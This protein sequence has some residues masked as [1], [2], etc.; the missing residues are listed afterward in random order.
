[1]TYI[2][3]PGRHHLLTNFQFDYLNQIA[4][5]GLAGIKDIDGKSFSPNEKVD[6]VVFAITS[7]NHANTRRN[8]LPLYQRAM[9]VQ[10]FSHDL[11]IKTTIYDINDIGVSESFADYVLKRIYSRSEGSLKLTP[12]NTIVA[13]STPVLEMYKKLGFRILPVELLSKDFKRYADNLPWEIIEEVANIQ[14]NWMENKLYKGKTHPAS[15]RLWET[16]DIGDKVQQ[17]FRDTIIG[18][19]GD[20][21]ETRD[22]NTYVR[23]MDHSTEQKYSE[24]S[25]FVK[26]G[27][28]GDIGCAVGSWIKFA[29][30]DSRLAESDFYGIEVTRKLYDICE[31]RKD[32]GEFSS[33]Y[34]FFSRK[35]AITGLVFEPDSMD[36]IL[37]SSLTHEIESYGGRG[38]LL[39]FIKNRAAELNEGGRWIN[40]DVV[41]PDDGSKTVY[42]ELNSSDGRNDDY[43]QAIGN[44]DKLKEYLDGLSTYAKFLRFSKDFRKN[45]SEQVKYEAV[46][47]DNKNLIKLQLKDACEFV[48]KK[49]YTDN[50][51]SEMHE[52][53][54]FW[55][56][57]DWKQHLEKAGLKVHPQSKAFVNPWVIK[58]RVQGK[59]KLYTLQD[60][61]LNEIDYPVSNMVLVAEKR[62]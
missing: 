56:F 14:D 49:D 60:K 18:E 28:I 57:D 58:K 40:R 52:T 1:M 3:F 23:S 61:T 2:L 35:N 10:D 32:N 16:Y 53:F 29:C 25:S 42:L 31:Q 6:E 5:E 24:T 9:A 45:E 55:S 59:V 12:D 38:D 44:R 20:I 11:P 43:D 15:K 22:Y 46:S 36:S 4:K 17:L 62:H 48:T 26:P 47:I 33:D 37:T 30:Q 50:W 51:Q 39:K 41:G 54:C 8:P 13:C 7:A 27:R 34:V 21:T 19:D